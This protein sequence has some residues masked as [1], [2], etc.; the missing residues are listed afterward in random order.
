MTTSYQSSP[1]MFTVNDSFKHALLFSDLTYSKEN[2]IYFRKMSS[3]RYVWCARQLLAEEKSQVY[4]IELFLRHNQEMPFP[5]KGVW[6][7]IVLTG[8]VTKTCSFF[9]TKPKKT[10]RDWSGMRSY[11]Y[12]VRK[13]TLIQLVKLL[14]LN[15]FHVFF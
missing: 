8:S 10:M 13:P 14:T 5:S 4:L 15:I 6:V 7:A 3:Q 1:A 9:K 2:S 11:D 12:Q